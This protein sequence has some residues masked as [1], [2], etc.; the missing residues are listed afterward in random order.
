MIR[1]YVHFKHDL[2][3][4][5]ES[6][7]ENDQGVQHHIV[8]YK[9]TPHWLYA[10]HPDKKTAIKQAKANFEKLHPVM[11]KK[12]KAE[13]KKPTLTVMKT[14]PGFTPAAMTSKSDH[15]LWTKKHHTSGIVA[16]PADHLYMAIYKPTKAMVG[17]HHSL[18]GAKALGI[19]HTTGKKVEA[20]DIKLIKSTP[21]P[22]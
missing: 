18:D 1:A 12:L 7:M 11:T 13:G 3:G 8:F 22:P 6:L 15:V 21:R 4:L 5:A 10:S 19:S 20:K 14:M 2:P 9:E 17:L 16:A